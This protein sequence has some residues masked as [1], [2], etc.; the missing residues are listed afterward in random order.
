M[1]M[2]V[3]RRIFLRGLGGAVVAAPFLSSLGGRGAK[4]QSVSPPK[5][6]IVMFT[7]FGC[8]TTRFFPAK[9]HGVLAASD[10]LPTTL[11]P[12]AP[13]VSKLLIPR[14]IR[15][16]NEW[17]ATMARGQGNDSYLNVLGSYFT[18]QPIS[19]NSDDPFSFNQETKFRAMPVGPSL[20]HVMAQQLSPDGTPLLMNVSGQLKDGAQTA[21]SY[22]AAATLFNSLPIAHAFSKL[23]G[24]YQPGV[25]TT[26]DSYQAARGKS[27]LDLVQHDLETLE[28]FDMSRSD[29]MK[30]AAWKELLHE[31]GTAIVTAQCSQGVATTL[32]ATQANLDAL[33][34]RSPDY[35]SLTNKITDSLDAADV[36]S[37]VA[38]LSAACNANP[39]IVLKYPSTF[40]FTGLGINHDSANLSRRRDS[41]STNG[42]CLPNAIEML[43]KIDGYYAEKFAKLVGMLDGIPEGD[44]TTTLDNSAAVWF[45]EVSDGAA[46][47]LNNLPII[48]AGGAAG[49]FK[50]GWTINVEDASPNLTQ[51]KSESACTPGT[52]D[53]ID[54]IS[55]S[56]GT[57]PKLANAPINKYYCNL[58]NAFGVKAG[59]DGFPAKGGMADVSKFGMYDKTEDFVGGGTKPPTIHD[60]GEFAVL[61]A[62]A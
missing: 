37:A 25:P 44:G 58:M 40:Q 6:L 45:Q 4:A 5:R 53:M 38:V 14:G 1:T 54:G 9:S 55:Q 24:L 41:A 62:K 49:Y 8:I 33:A 27:V 11:A 51:G 20:D 50:T 46:R 19:P 7:H 47:N 23:T 34:T 31:T 59:A 17:T 18:C 36:Y 26:P 28:R 30:L 52:T 21:I 10:L 13:Y 57:D 60:P 61:N 22:A 15:A 3:N 2:P 35:D 32:G 56:T 16:M 43:L 29:R 42:P 12:L 48:Q 39:V